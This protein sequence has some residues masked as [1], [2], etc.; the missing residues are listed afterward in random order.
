MRDSIDIPGTNV[1]CKIVD[2]ASKSTDRIQFP[3]GEAPCPSLCM[4][5]LGVHLSESVLEQ[6]NKLAA[7]LSPSEW[8]E[9]GFR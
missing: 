1:I 4:A 6:I 8:L 9:V 5:G 7:H 2:S 3:H